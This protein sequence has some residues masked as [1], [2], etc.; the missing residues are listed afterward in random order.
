MTSPD[1]MSREELLELA[2]LDAF[3][4]LDEV[5]SAMFNRAFHHAPASV[6]AEVRALQ[7]QL[8]E[9][10][11]FLSD[12]DPR[13]ILRQKV[14]VRVAEEIE[15]AAERLKPLATI[16]S[17]LTGSLA[18]SVAG[19]LAGSSVGS[20][21]QVAGTVLAAGA[22]AAT[23]VRRAG[24]DS[25][26]LRQ[27]DDRDGGDDSM[28]ELVAEIRARAALAER[29]R[30]TPYWRAAAFFLAAGLVASLYFLGSTMRTAEEIAR[31][32]SNRV[33]SEQLR[34]AVPDLTDFIFRDSLHRTLASADMAVDAT[35]TLI[36]NPETRETLL[37]GFGLDPNRGPYILRSVDDQGNATVVSTFEAD[38]PVSYA[39]ASVPADFASRKFE[40][41][42]GSGKVILRSA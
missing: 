25:I 13:P 42:D 35:A 24:A 32:A 26:D 16:G 8:A 39:I 10:A 17:S 2:P 15:D 36:I 9:Q 40:L 19:S 23:P 20:A 33:I 11:S 34:E 5:E 41:L 21:M 31:Q 6:Q 18:G 7:A 22:A 30:S 1:P 28:R 3:G 4:F 38:G 14:I 27:G 29:D 12:E 37:M